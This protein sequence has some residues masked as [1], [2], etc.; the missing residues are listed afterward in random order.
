MP[1]LFNRYE[2]GVL[3]MR[4]FIAAK[5][6]SSL[7]VLLETK[8]MSRSEITAK[9]RA[10]NSIAGNDDLGILKKMYLSIEEAHLRMMA[11]ID[12]K[13]LELPELA[14]IQITSLNTGLDMRNVK[15][16]FL[17]YQLECMHAAIAR[18]SEI[19]LNHY[20]N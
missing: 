7:H 18:M 12:E 17:P 6:G 16:L 1:L 8:P 14:N 13:K 19:I 4:A 15:L 3:P 10:H 11:F 20:G 9:Q 5:I 2:F